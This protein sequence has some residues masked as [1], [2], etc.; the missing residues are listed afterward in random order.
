MKEQKRNITMATDGFLD[1]V[2]LPGSDIPATKRFYTEVD[3][4]NGTRGLIGKSAVLLL[5]GA[6]HDEENETDD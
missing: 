2:E 1:Y 5:N 4:E 3:P 6:D